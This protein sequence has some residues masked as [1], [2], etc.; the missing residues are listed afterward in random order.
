MKSILEYLNSTLLIV[1]VGVA[2]YQQVTLNEIAKDIRWSSSVTEANN[3]LNTDM[4]MTTAQIK[5]QLDDM[6]LEMVTIQV[7][8]DRLKYK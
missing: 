1:L 5:A 8:V 4:Y 3:E 2:G 7:D 6:E